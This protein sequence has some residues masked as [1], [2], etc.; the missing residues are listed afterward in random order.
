MLFLQNCGDEDTTIPRCLNIEN[1]NNPNFETIS[2][3]NSNEW[4][5]KVSQNPQLPE[6]EDLSKEEKTKFL[7]QVK[8]N[9]PIE[10][11]Y[12]YEDLLCK[13]HDK[14]SKDKQDQGKAMNFEH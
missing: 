8:I 13:H 9:V 3:I 5:I 1:V 12:Q 7:A 10:E 11:K 2:E 14:F 6:P 4:E